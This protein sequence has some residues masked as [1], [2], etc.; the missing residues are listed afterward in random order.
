MAE[1]EFYLKVC[2]K[3]SMVFSIGDGVFKLLN[4]CWFDAFGEKTAGI[5]K[6]SPVPSHIIRLPIYIGI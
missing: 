2:L 4:S 3:N 5:P 1:G 6:L